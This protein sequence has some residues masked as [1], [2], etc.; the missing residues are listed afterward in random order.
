MNT[1][2]NEF[3]TRTSFST[4]KFYLYCTTYSTVNRQVISSN[5]GSCY[6]FLF[7]NF[8][9][10][11]EGK[12]KSMTCMNTEDSLHTCISLRIQFFNLASAVSLLHFTSLWDKTQKRNGKNSCRCHRQNN[13]LKKNNTEV[14]CMFAP[15]EWIIN[16]ILLSRSEQFSTCRPEMEIIWILLSP[17]YSSQMNAHLKRPSQGRVALRYILSLPPVKALLP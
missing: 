13:N 10:L 14:P 2:L 11:C 15:S 17:K 4:L 8:V 9:A 5:N 3:P 16:T 6:K 7:C 1:F 12:K